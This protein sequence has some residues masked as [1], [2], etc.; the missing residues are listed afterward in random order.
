MSRHAH[1]QTD[2]PELSS[3]ALS[4]LARRHAGSGPKAVQ[5]RLQQCTGEVRTEPERRRAQGKDDPS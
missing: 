5:D 4:R 1:M 2:Q 3:T